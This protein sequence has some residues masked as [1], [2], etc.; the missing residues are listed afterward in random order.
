LTA[1]VVASLDL[2]NLG[3]GN[4][5]RFFLPHGAFRRENLLFFAG[6]HDESLE[7]LR[8]TRPY[9]VGLVRD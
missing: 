5:G 1:V 6:I 4:L 2:G 8:V 3:L 7:A 9:A